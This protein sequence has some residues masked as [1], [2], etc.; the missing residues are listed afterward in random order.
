MLY[1]FILWAVIGGFLVILTTLRFM[2]P[3]GQITTKVRDSEIQSSAGTLSWYYR[4][5]RGTTAT[6]RR[7]LL[8]E[9]FV[10]FF[11]HVTRL[12]V[13]ILTILLGYLLIF[14]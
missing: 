4:A 14:T 7:Y 1:T 9:S 11:G 13:L 8:P 12:Q 5:W 2:R 6:F 3:L 10:K